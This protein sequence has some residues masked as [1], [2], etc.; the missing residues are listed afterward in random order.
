L[1][2]LDWLL[3]EAD[4]ERRSPLK[5]LRDGLELSYRFSQDS[6]GASGGRV[7]EVG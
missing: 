1:D 5:G 6:S 7:T 3:E 4:E 2:E